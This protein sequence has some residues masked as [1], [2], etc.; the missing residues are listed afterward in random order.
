MAA[1]IANTA[2][3]TVSGKQMEGEC[4]IGVDDVE[5]TKLNAAQAQQ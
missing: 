4:R 1:V 5:L 3:P 2:A